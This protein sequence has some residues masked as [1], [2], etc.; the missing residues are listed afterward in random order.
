MSL[1]LHVIFGNNN[2]RGLNL[3]PATFFI[4][5]FILYKH[6]DLEFLL[7]L[8]IFLSLF[9]TAGAVLSVGAIEVSYAQF[10]A[11]ITVII[12]ICSGHW[13]K[14]R[15]E[16][17]FYL[18]WTAFFISVLLSYVFTL[19]DFFN[20][21]LVYATG[22]DFA[23]GRL[24][25]PE[26]SFSNIK[27]LINLILY[28]LICSLVVNAEQNKIKDKVFSW[29]KI[30]IIIIFIEFITKNIFNSTIFIDIV[31]FFFGE[32][33]YQIDFL[34]ERAGYNALQGFTREPNHLARGLFILLVGLVL[35]KDKSIYFYVTMGAF[36]LFA[37]GSFAGF[38][39]VFFLC[40][41]IVVEKFNYKIFFTIPVLIL[42]LYII[43]RNVD[44]HYYLDRAENLKYDL[45]IIS[46]V[47][48]FDVFI[49]S[50]FFGVG[51]GN[52]MSFGTLS[53]LL[54]NLGL[55]GSLL[56]YF[57]SAH[58]YELN[59]KRNMIMAIII[60]S[61]LFTG[62]KG[63]VYSFSTI[64]IFLTLSVSFSRKQHL[65]AGISRSP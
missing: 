12:A 59:R 65:V 20:D 55:I 57:S 48:S 2:P 39:F 34:F 40:A 14:K 23:N 49:S 25:I 6:K 64:F 50:P 7:A 47:K 61:F 42:L 5:S 26:F 24:T 62:G 35:T 60:F 37:S 27:E 17:S 13:F 30:L 1:K 41:I 53:T 18:K 33:K 38:S 21:E 3:T 31:H 19:F 11:V 16:F 51:F 8:T 36:L 32:A 10:S 4:L 45:R 54:S 9:F 22:D 44:F 58:G 29:S 46:I 43:S 52:S 28:F 63:T 15:N 56:W